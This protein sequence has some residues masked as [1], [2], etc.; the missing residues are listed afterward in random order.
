V[1]FA[2][3]L[4]KEFSM[5]HLPIIR[6]GNPVTNIPRRSHRQVA[7]TAAIGKRQEQFVERRKSQRDRRKQRQDFVMERRVTCDR[8]RPRIDFSV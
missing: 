6:P 4:G 3:N 7:G 2:D 1:V 8:R 5:V